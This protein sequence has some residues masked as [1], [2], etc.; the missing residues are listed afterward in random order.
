MD[1]GRRL[2]HVASALALLVT[3]LFEASAALPAAGHAATIEPGAPAA[4]VLSRAAATATP[5]RT[6]TRTATATATATAT[7]TATAIATVTGTTPSPTATNA[8]A[9]T[10]LSGHVLG[11]L[12]RATPLQATPSAAAAPSLQAAPNAATASTPITLTIVLKRSDQA[13]FDAFVRDVHDAHSPRFRH[14]ASQ[15]E[16]AQRFGPTQQAHDA[17]LA[18]LQQNGFTVVGRSAGRLTITVQGTL[19]QVNRV[20][21]AHVGTYQLNGRTFYA[22]SV[23]PT[24]PTA[25]APYVQAI[26]GLSNFAV[27]HRSVLAAPLDATNPTPATPMSIGTAYNYNGVQVSG[28][29]ATGAGQ[30]IGLVEFA[31]FNESDVQTFIVQSGLCAA[32]DS[33]CISGFLGRLTVVPLSGTFTRR[34]T[35][36]ETEVLLDLDTVLGLAQGA[37]YRVYESCNNCAASV[38][39]QDMFNRMID[40]NVTVISNSW[41]VC[42]T[43]VPQSTATSI[44]SVLQQ[45]AASGISV[46]NAAGDDGSTCVGGD[47]TVYPN[48]VTVPADAP[49]GIAVGGTNLQV[50]SGNAYH[51]EQ[52]WSSTLSNSCTSNASAGGFGTSIYFSAPPWQQ[53]LGLSQRSV[54]D[55]SA[56]ASPCSGI[57]IYHGG[58]PLDE[59][60]TSMAAPIWAAGT[61]LVNQARGSLTGNWNQ[62][63]Y[64][65]RNTNAFHAPSSMLPP[66]NDF[67]HLGL[68][69]PNLA[70]LAAQVIPTTPTGSPTSTPTGTRTTTVTAVPSQTATAT[71]TFTATATSTPTP[72]AT[73]TPIPTAT[74]TLPP[75]ATSTSSVAPTQPPSGTPGVPC[76]PVVGGTCTTTGAVSGTWTKTGSGTF[77]FAA[78]GPANALAGAVP[79]ISIPTTANANGEQFA[80]LPTG[81]GFATTCTGTTAGDVLLGA[82]I[83]VSFPLAGGG[84]A[85][86]TGTPIGTGTAGSPSLSAAQAQAQAQATAGFQ[87]GS[88]GLPCAAGIGQTC[89]VNGALSGSLSRTGS[90]SFT[91][92]AVVPAGVPAGIVPLA[93]FSTDQ[94]LQTAACAA[95]T[96]GVGL[97]YSCTGTITGNALQGSTAA[98]C[99][100]TTAP[101]LLGTVIGAG[102]L[103]P[104]PPPPG[105]LPPPPLPPPPPPA[106]PP[107][108]PPPPALSLPPPPL[109]PPQPALGLA[110]APA[111]PPPVFPE[112]PVIPEAD[113]MPLLAG[114]LAVLGVLGALRRRRS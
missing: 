34:S 88:L 84:F 46:F 81:V 103:P 22:N 59:G 16:L 102:A 61:A 111:P 87:L 40:D 47:G 27:P 48:T 106:A 70:N 24:L 20:F 63:L 44:D 107:P 51:G 57:T 60:G 80:C 6:P 66:D 96:G 19:D 43:E 101:C 49:N 8:V 32:S 26:E 74:A 73:S 92:T 77:A 110:A 15:Q 7:R 52:W 58:Q 13:G 36:G 41:S 98:L 53:A 9:G 104:V 93:V 2:V 33:A 23:D 112:V 90:M 50:D 31:S 83:T 1:R 78:T 56:D 82:T 114:G 75:T 97:A 45:A 105:A 28:A 85:T 11:L 99:F 18:Y 79:T 72:T 100:T 71:G 91:L 62:V 109:L 4:S 94:G 37:N 17:V 69:S 54:P 86:V 5:P 42:E 38:S 108:P 30:T 21:D 113:S 3:I 55:V 12:S 68:G 64:S 67:A 39:F 95:P 29:P 25:L 10:R 35:G 14:F 89:T 76:T 65:L